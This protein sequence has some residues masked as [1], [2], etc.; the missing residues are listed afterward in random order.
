VVANT[1][2]D[3]E[4]IVVD[5]ASTD[6]TRQ[7]LKKFAS[8]HHRVQIHLNATN[9]GF[10]GGNNDGIR[11]ANGKFIVLLNNDTLVPAGWLD[12]LL[13]R[14]HDHPEIGLIGPVTN[15]AGNEQR[16]ELKDLNEKN[17]EQ[18][19]GD[20]LKRQEGILFPTEKLGFFCVAIRKEVID[21]IGLLDETFGIGMFE[22]DD[23]CVRA[24]FAGYKLAVV[25]DCFVYH[26]G[27]VSF[28]KLSLEYYSE[29]FEK[30]RAYF[31][32]KH[33]IAWTFSDLA[34]SYLNNIDRNVKAFQIHHNSTSPEFE[35]IAVR[36]NNFQHLMVL[37]HQAEL[38]GHISTNNVA[39]QSPQAR[40]AFWKNR[41][42][43]FQNYFIRGN[44]NERRHYIRLVMRWFM[45]KFKKPKRPTDMD[46]VIA[47]LVAIHKTAL[48]RKIIIF[49]AT[50]DFHYMMQRPQ[51]LAKAFAKKGYLVIYG[52]LCH[53]S[54]SVNISERV[55]ENLYLVHESHFELLHHAFQPEDATY[56]C[57]WPNNIQHLDY[58]PY[59]SLIYDFM[60]DLSLLDLPQDIL[61]LNHNKLFQ[62][63]NLLTVSSDRL[64]AKIPKVYRQK[65][66]LINNAVSDDFIDAVNI[67]DNSPNELHHCGH[68]PVVGYYGAIAEWFDFEIIEL[69]AKTLPHA[70]IVLIG[71]I[72]VKVS[73]RLE[74]LAM[75]H[76]NIMLFPQR[77][78]LELV[79]FLKRFDVCMIPFVKTDVTDAV[80]PVKLFEYFSAGKPVVATDIS[81]CKKYKHIFCAKSPDEFVQ[82]IQR[83]LDQKPSE[84]LTN[85]LI[86]FARNNTWSHRVDEI[87]SN[88]NVKEMMAN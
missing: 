59:S 74:K 60:D 31:R 72:D 65:S 47:E 5:N 87:I 46:K 51:Q 50:V 77:S 13:R 62:I 39:N 67:C 21:K 17:Y 23:Y 84:S 29:L 81:E 26:K 22:D 66:L 40:A 2:G 25:E 4:L 11:L 45:Q 34:F 69:L 56:Y 35:R 80:S 7:S 16:I 20:Y 88:L 79:P 63:A 86:K 82:A 53:Q 70:T 73:M 57:L 58:I 19:A 52:T 6:G 12:R 10:A 54:D 68:E 37:V 28:S 18:I 76:P 27:S 71:P 75:N 30:N 49:P 42:Q 78:Q 55:S 85:G 3:Y 8:R 64:M 32:A 41:L 14:F 48:K 44:T 24:K 83:L 43:Q 33:G 38:N 61:E 36:I 1:V 9:R 15:S